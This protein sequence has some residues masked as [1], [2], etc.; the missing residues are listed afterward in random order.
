MMA[1]ITDMMNPADCPGAYIP[2]TRPSQVATTDPAIPKSI[3]IMIP[4]GSLPGMRNLATTPITNPT[5]ATHNHSIKVSC[6]ESALSLDADGEH[7]YTPRQIPHSSSI[8][9]FFPST[10]EQ[11]LSS[12]IG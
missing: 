5:K 11:Q 2:S 3:V 12:E 6:A 7:K 10:S 1:P 8:F 4:P 9:S